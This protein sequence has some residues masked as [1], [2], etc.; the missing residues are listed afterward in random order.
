ML[1]S[2][3]TLQLTLLDDEV[4]QPEPVA[5]RRL[6]IKF[7]PVTAEKL[8]TLV[9]QEL[10]LLPLLV[11]YLYSSAMVPAP[12]LPAETLAVNV[13]PSQTIASVG[14]LVSPGAEG[15]ATTGNKAPLL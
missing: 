8:G 6:S 2:A 10:Q 4:L 5:V 14:F 13:K 11:E 15:S 7:V 9:F 12:P 1:G 3:A